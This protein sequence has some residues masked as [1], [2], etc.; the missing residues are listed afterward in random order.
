MQAL[1]GEAEVQLSSTVLLYDLE[2][3]EDTLLLSLFYIQN[4]VW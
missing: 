1:S 3:E 2:W 4:L